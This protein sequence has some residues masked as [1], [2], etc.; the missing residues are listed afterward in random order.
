M[1]VLII[2]D[3]AGVRESLAEVLRD[4]GYEVHLAADGA[5]ALRA[6]A[7]EP[8]PSL[9]LLD[10]MMP[11]MSGFD[12]R[13]HQQKDPRLSHI[14]VILISARPDLPKQA[15]ELGAQD[16]LPK[17]MSFEALLHAVQNRAITVV[18]SSS[19]P[20]KPRT[21]QQAWRAVRASLA[22]SDDDDDDDDDGD[23]DGAGD[24]PDAR[25]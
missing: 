7:A 22:G 10:L 2:E 3:D 16:F 9:I 5:A 20:G 19:L 14:P 25:R 8:L 18:A 15:R 23:E 24:P 11:G 21:L 1:S 17:P 4:E 13:A 12:F 6:L